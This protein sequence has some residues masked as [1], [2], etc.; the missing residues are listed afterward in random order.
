MNKENEIASTSFAIDS[1]GESRLL[2]DMESGSGIASIDSHQLV[3]STTAIYSLF[4][5]NSLFL[6]QS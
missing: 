4:S 6:D 3:P 2:T 5:E 1:N